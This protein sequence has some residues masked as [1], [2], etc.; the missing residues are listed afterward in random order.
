M[1]S[2]SG[3]A[4]ARSLRV[5]GA[6]AQRARLTVVPRTL[7]RP[8][9]MPFAILTA[10]ALIGG[11]VGLL[12]F[13][14]NMAAA[15]FRVNDL[16]QQLTSLQAREDRLNLSLDKLN[17]PRRL[18]RRA[19][20]LG[21]VPLGSPSFLRLSDGRVLGDPT[22]ASKPVRAKRAAGQAA[23]DQPGGAPAT[24]TSAPSPTERATTQPTA[25]PT[26]DGS[27]T[28]TGTKKHKGSP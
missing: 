28:S 4:R 15:S 12:M 26:S 16:Q 2:A 3:A 27:A 19:K 20:A 8:P 7:S 23:T 1:S 11:V 21:M 6:A 24:P 10:V 14:T 13:N 5:A 22:V 9:Q 25:G 17:D 18:A